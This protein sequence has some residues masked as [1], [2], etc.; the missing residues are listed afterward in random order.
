MTT[1]ED[2]WK[3]KVK[4]AEKFSTP[5][6]IRVF[7]INRVLNDYFSTQE[8]TT[9]HTKAIRSL[10]ADVFT[11]KHDQTSAFTLLSRLST[12]G[13]KKYMNQFREEKHYNIIEKIFNTLISP[14]FGQEYSIITTYNDQ[15]KYK[16]SVF[17]TSDLMCLIFQFLE[18]LRFGSIT[19]LSNC[20]LVCS[21]WLYHSFNPN[22][23]H[24]VI[25]GDSGVNLTSPNPNSNV[26]R[27]KHV[28]RRFWQRV[29]NAR[30]IKINFNHIS[31][32]PDEYLL[33]HVLTFGNI[34]EI[35]GTFFPD[36]VSV[37]QGIMQQC[38]DKIKIIECAVWIFA[39]S[40][41]TLKEFPILSPL[42]L[43]NCKKISIS[44]L[45]FYILWSNKCR[46]LILLGIENIDKN[47]CN[48]VIDN[49][50]CSNIQYLRLDNVKFE[51][52]IDQIIVSKLAQKFVDLKNLEIMLWDQG[53]KD[54]SLFWQSLIPII[55]KNNSYV[56]IS[57]CFFFRRS[58]IAFEKFIDNYKIKI[59]KIQLS[60]NSETMKLMSN[61]IA[62]ND[63]LEIIDLYC[64]GKIGS[65]IKTTTSFIH[66]LKRALQ[67]EKQEKLRKFNLKQ[68]DN[69]VPMP[70]L[71]KIQL[72]Q[73]IHESQM[74]KL[75]DLMIE[76]IKIINNLE[77]DHSICIF[78]KFV[79]NKFTAVADNTVDNCLVL[80]RNVWETINLLIEIKDIGINVEVTIGSAAESIRNKMK[81][82][83]LSVFG[84]DKSLSTYK[85]PKCNKYCKPLPKLISTVAME[86][87]KIILFCRNCENK[88]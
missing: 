44:N 2:D 38:S 80:L 60:I 7:T 51:S 28:E 8:D 1:T 83:F 62:K 76:L 37:L 36:Q 41:E 82:V 75:H 34:E 77:N 15:D 14:K 46:E 72:Y 9:D 30:C 50:D 88:C 56:D 18:Y 61:M 21:Y 66:Y 3:V 65:N 70:S 54:I 29:I 43:L 55:E 81:Q 11:N 87:D 73:R 74:S 48:F 47:W 4:P 64:D 86:H 45:Y 71:E 13:I 17:S 12:V 23:T 10:L 33:S 6:F 52:N 40:K 20:S 85:E 57:T 39:P 16:S 69:I 5:T 59:N 84:S 26:N 24:G 63:E 53:I 19:D 67:F 49:C 35:Y 27:S 79:V 31:P 78:L 22:S 42:K 25:I 32:K 68:S 58:V